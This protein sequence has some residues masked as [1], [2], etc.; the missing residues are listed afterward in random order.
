MLILVKPI[1]SVGFPHNELGPYN[2]E[3]CMIEE[4]LCCLNAKAPEAF[5]LYNIFADALERTRFTRMQ[6]TCGT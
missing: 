3:L 5:I 4:P 6:K 2:C 1:H